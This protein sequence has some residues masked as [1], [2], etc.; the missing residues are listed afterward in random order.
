LLRQRVTKLSDRNNHARTFALQARLFDGSLTAL[1]IPACATVIR[2]GIRGQTLSKQRLKFAQWL[3]LG[4]GR[5]AGTGENP[6]AASP[7]RQRAEALRA[8]RISD[9]AL[10]AITFGAECCIACAGL[11]A[12]CPRANPALENPAPEAPSEACLLLDACQTGGH[13]AVAVSWPQQNVLRRRRRSNE[14]EAA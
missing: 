6:H 7:I 10:I 1:P 4:I 13:A 2:S 9:A 12:A 3:H 11:F 8:P 5:V 14:G